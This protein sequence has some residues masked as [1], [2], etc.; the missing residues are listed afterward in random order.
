MIH[1]ESLT[2]RERDILQLML[3]D[4]SNA[5]IAERLVMTVGTVR[6]YVS[7]IYNKL[8]VHSRDEAIA[9]AAEL[10]PA[11]QSPPVPST[12]TNLPART[13]SLVGR[14]RE[15]E[16][17]RQRLLR[18]DVRLL[19]LVGAPG[20]G[21]TRL[22]L[23]TA[24]TLLNEF[25]NGVYFVSLAPLSDPALVAGAIGGA[26]GVQETGGQSIADL[27]SHYLREKS[28]LLVLDNFEHLLDAAPLVAELLAASPRLKVLA[29]SREPLHVYGEQEYPV[30]PLAFPDL[31]VSDGGETPGDYEAVALFVRRAQAVKPE[32]DLTPE[33]AETV[34]SICVRL[35]G[36]PLAIE[37]AAARVKL[38]SPNALLER[39]NK[40]LS[41][42]SGGARDLPERQ[43]TLRGAIAWS[44]DL[45]SEAEQKL[46]AR[47]GVFVG[48]W[49]LEA[50][51]A[52]CSADL[53]IDV[54]DGLESLLNK[55]LIQQSADANGEPRFTMLEMIREFALEKLAESGAEDAV[56]QAHG[57][58]FLVF[59]ENAEAHAFESKHTA[60]FAQLETELDNLRSALHWSVRAGAAEMGLQL[61]AA[62]AWFFHTRLYWNEG[63]DWLERLLAFAPD[64]PALVRLKA[65]RKAGDIAGWLGDVKHASALSRASLALAREVNDTWSVAKSLSVLAF[66][67]LDDL[68]QSA[69]LLDESL[70]L[71]R[72]L[73]TPRDISQ[74][75][76]R[77]AVIAIQQGEYSYART[78]LEE[79][80]TLARDL[81]DIEGIGWALFVL[82]WALWCQDRNFRLTVPLYRESLSLF[83][84]IRD[85]FGIA[86]VSIFLAGVEQIAENYVL[87]RT[88][89]EETMLL[90]RET[91]IS[92]LFGLILAGLGSLAKVA[93]KLERAARLFAAG[94]STIKEYFPNP[95]L[96]NRAAFDS[97][98][99]SV[100]AQLGESAFLAA[101]ADGA[102]MTLDQAV[103]YALEDK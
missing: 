58:Y 94:E 41:M 55:S 97:D 5:E 75:L 62:L 66:A 26:L 79:S 63:L 82:G 71:F 77:R 4:L 59:A 21:K 23:E 8:D 90:V 89:Y 85:V 53:S 60:W 17:V 34:V 83:R 27:L 46:F 78:L 93:G 84:D 7:Q 91:G 40:R 14:E 54:F 30:P 102:Q 52:V 33:N 24:A 74:I 38:H 61:A 49:S 36:L 44:Y 43:Q 12:P 37:L 95:H 87:S 98:V 64:A 86:Y 72:E 69:A 16:A 9:R 51:E 42:L 81:D 50:M 2:P 6:W 68:N 25:P 11:P 76:H 15:I 1:L 88:L 22:S 65:L 73:E 10:K 20:I 56:R 28:L 96:A 70:T 57:N 80:L 39:L 45:L 47:L 103:A 99:A 29:T 13:T 92:S 101:W 100:R 67:D 3:A 18:E 35:D 48:G 31:K 19:T 32:F